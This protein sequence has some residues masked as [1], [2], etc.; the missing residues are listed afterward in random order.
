MALKKV[1]Y[2]IKK[3][4]CIKVYELKKKNRKGKMVV[5]KV[6]YQR[7]ALKKGTK[8]Y[9]TK[10]ECTKALNK[11]KK[12][13][14]KKKQVVKHKKTRFGKECYYSV[15]HFGTMVPNIAKSWS[16]TQDSGITSSAWMW[17]TPPSAKAYDLQQGSWRKM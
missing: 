14:D 9:K 3:G 12:R 7:K 16:G 13:N 6:N 5:K 2:Y 11:M 8:V 4:K 17:P 10:A 15:P 1:G